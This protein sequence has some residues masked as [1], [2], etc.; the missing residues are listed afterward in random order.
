MT[1][2]A[3]QSRALCLSP[4]A[5]TKGHPARGHKRSSGKETHQRAAAD[6]R[7]AFKARVLASVLDDQERGLIGR[8][9]V[10]RGRQAILVTETESA[11]FHHRLYTAGRNRADCEHQ[12]VSFSRTAG[13]ID[14]ALVGVQGPLA[15]SGFVDANAAENP[16]RRR[17][18][19]GKVER[20]FTDDITA[21]GH[22]DRRLVPAQRQVRNAMRRTG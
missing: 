11:A 20:P 17:F 8:P 1:Q 10:E 18:A 4:R 6:V 9:C 14:L 3:T 21:L 12:Y 19:E 16:V 15:F 5:R 13:K 7:V 22:V 2:R